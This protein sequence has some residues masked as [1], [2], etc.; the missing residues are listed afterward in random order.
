M[1]LYIILFFISSSLFGQ[2]SRSNDSITFKLNNKNYYLG[3]FNEVYL[4]QNDSLIR[5]D[6][7]VDS[8]VTINSYV[9]EINDTI[10]KYGGYGFWS[11]RNFMYYFDFSSSEWELYKITADNQI[12]GSFAGYHNS[13]E[14]RIFFYGGKEVSSENRLQQLRSKEVVEFN[15]KTRELKKIGDLNLDF[16]KKTF[17][18]CNNKYSLFF[19]SAFI[20]KVDPFSNK[21]SKYYKPTVIS[22][23]IINAEYSSQKRVFEIKKTLDKTGE[24]DTIILSDNFLLNPI[25]S[26]KF[27]ENPSNLYIS[28]ILLFLMLISLFVVRKKKLSAITII[29][30]QS[31]IHK[32]SLYDFDF[33]NIK[34]LKLLIIQDEVN[35][36]SL[37]E[38]YSN[39]DLSYGHITRITNQQI[40]KLSIRLKSIFKL[41]NDPI[42]K[43]KSKIDKRQR[44]I[45]LSDEF[46]DISKKIKINS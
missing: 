36:N 23:S 3:A 40:D 34:L 28:F 11:Q 26:Y 25:E 24:I 9:F 46:R 38:L 8:R 27:Y 42:I 15:I 5:I 17:F 6:K 43:I 16:E 29:K 19:D 33:E 13:D 4:I 18:Y 31:I 45:L 10:I 14:N 30:S 35:F 12:N 39:S 21:V 7:S 32:G 22:S 20:Y 1:K 41:K 37:L 2:L 44:T